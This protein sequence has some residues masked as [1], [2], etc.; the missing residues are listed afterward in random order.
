MYESA[1]AET[2]ESRTNKTAMPRKEQH[3]QLKAA[4]AAASR[5][6]TW[7]SADWR[8]YSLLFITLSVHSLIVSLY[9]YPNRKKKKRMK[10][11][12]FYHRSQF[13]LDLLQ[14]RIQERLE[15]CSTSYISDWVISSLFSNNHWNLCS[16]KILPEDFFFFS[17]KCCRQWWSWPK[18][19]LLIWGGLYSTFCI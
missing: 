9:F 13:W 3:A 6:S 4:A 1:R 7:K 5:T 19:P 12:I 11:A 8:V 18:A 15:F 14:R 2:C 16:V 10:Y 17:I